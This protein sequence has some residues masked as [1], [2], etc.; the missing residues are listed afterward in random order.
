MNILFSHELQDAWCVP[1]LSITVYDTDTDNVIC[2]DDN[3]EKKYTIPKEEIEKICSVIKKHPNV[4][5]LTEED[6]EDAGVLDG[7]IDRFLF[8]DRKKSNE[9]FASNIWAFQKSNSAAVNAKSVISV[10]NRISEILKNN[11]IDNCF[12]RLNY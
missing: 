9:L 1:I 7:T 12:L 3:G 2:C 5:N 6:I 10:F 8:S 11:G 4:L